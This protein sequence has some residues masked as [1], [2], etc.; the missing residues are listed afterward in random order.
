MLNLDY[1]RTP[2]PV[3]R[4]RPHFGRT[5]GRRVNF[6]QLRSARSSPRRQISGRL[7]RPARLFESHLVEPR[8]FESHLVVCFGFCWRPLVVGC[9]VPLLSWQVTPLLHT[10]AS[11]LHANPAKRRRRSP[12]RTHA[13]GFCRRSPHG[14]TPRPTV[15]MAGSPLLHTVT[16]WPASLP[17]TVTCWHQQ[18]GVSQEAAAQPRPYQAHAKCTTWPLTLCPD[19]RAAALTTSFAHR[20]AAASWALSP[21]PAVSARRPEASPYDPRHPAL[22]W[23]PEPPPRPPSTGPTPRTLAEELLRAAR[24]QPTPPRPRSG[25]R[26]RCTAAPAVLGPG[27]ASLAAICTPTSTTR[28]TE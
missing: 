27:V 7:R 20:K 24:P 28:L 3:P 14:R 17:H 19:R 5:V 13:P 16:S 26:A 25:S 6:H 21:S 10:V 4:W 15:I 11:R 18:L 22:A 9:H 1:C 23:A 12:S 2:Q 8:V